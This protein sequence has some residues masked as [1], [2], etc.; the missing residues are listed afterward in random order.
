MSQ[1][2]GEGYLRGCVRVGGELCT[3]Q[4]FI[5]ILLWKLFTLA[6][7]KSWASN[8]WTI[9]W[10][11]RTST[12]SAL[13]GIGSTSSCQSSSHPPQLW[14]PSTTCSTTPCSATDSLTSSALSQLITIWCFSIILCE[15]TYYSNNNRGSIDLFL[16]P[17]LS[18]DFLH[19]A[20]YKYHHTSLKA[21]SILPRV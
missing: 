2:G 10:M 9:R 6:N 12:R 7:V 16:M 14:L 11:A 5:F 21:K 1:R 8:W 15:D 4:T 17:Q 13:F 3:L 20:V 19:S 18:A